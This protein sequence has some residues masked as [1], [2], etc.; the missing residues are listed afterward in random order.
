MRTSK[1]RKK[2]SFTDKQKKIIAVC[3]AA[4]LLGGAVFFFTYFHVKNVEVMGSEH[5]TEDEIKEMILRGPA[6]S[7]SILAPILYTK[8]ETEDIP[9]VEGFSVTRTARDTIVV[10][11]REKKAVGC[12]PYLDSYIYFDRN[13]VFI[14]GEKTRDESVPFFDGIQVERVVQDEELPIEDTVLNTAV[15]L[16]TIFA[17]NDTTPDHIQFDEKG[18]ISLLYGD[19]TVQLGRDEY[20]EDKMMRVISIL[21][22]IRGQKG[23]LHLENVTDSVKTITFEAEQEEITAENWTGGYD[24][25]GN[26]TGYDEYDENGNYVG[27]KPMTAMDYAL[28]NWVGGYDEEGDYTGAG[29]YDAYMNYVGPAPT[30]ET[31]D[32]MGDWT[33]GYDEEG[34]FTGTGEYD[35]EGNYV[36]PNPNASGS[37]EDGTASGEAAEDGGESEDSYSDGDSY[38]EESYSEE[39][40]YDDGDSG[41][42]DSGSEDSGYEESEYNDLYDEDFYE[43]YY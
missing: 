43:E 20:L 28:E 4:C 15:A 26:Y 19:I 17:K 33:G 11:I 1:Y 8:K 5:Y 31:I 7:N 12:I 38:E 29:E 37:E 3:A 6:A 36:G 41:Y 10:S 21:P 13:G 32:A 9:F 40:Y 23:I 27:P 34:G 35:R 39:P 18:S 16:S 42:E 2:I 30:Q 14:E 24:E 25:Y 22:Q